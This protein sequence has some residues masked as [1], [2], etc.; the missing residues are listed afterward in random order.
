MS[1]SS[2]LNSDQVEFVQLV[3]GRTG[4][5][6]Q[7]I[8]AWSLCEEPASRSPLE[9][10]HNWL[11]LLHRSVG[12]TVGYSGVRIVG[13]SPAGFAR[14]ASVGDAATETAHWVNVF[15]FYAGI[16]A[17]RG[18]T[19]QV[20]VA[21]IARSPWDA[22]HYGGGRVIAQLLAV[23][24]AHDPLTAPHHVLPGYTTLTVH[25]GPHAG[26]GTVRTRYPLLWLAR[27]RWAMR[28]PGAWVPPHR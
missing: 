7:T 11:N 4:L 10:G 27:H 25:A 22:G 19:P 2:L 28:E 16:R 5:H 9:Q 15:S 24:L 12:R 21:A 17:T 23:V 1:L 3:A 20:Q 13:W 26:A 6:Q 18:S 8:A 14:F